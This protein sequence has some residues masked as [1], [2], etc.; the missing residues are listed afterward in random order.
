[1]TANNNQALIQDQIKVSNRSNDSYYSRT[2]T[3]P[4]TL[5]SEGQIE[6]CEKVKSALFKHSTRNFHGDATGTGTHGNILENE[7]HLSLVVGPR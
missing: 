6:G 2:L 3:P 1:M 4:F 7:T 5:L